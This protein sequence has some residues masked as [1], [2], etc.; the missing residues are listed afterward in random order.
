VVRTAFAS[1]CGAGKLTVACSGGSVDVKTGIAQAH[2][3]AKYALRAQPGARAKL[4]GINVLLGGQA[5]PA[6]VSRA[7]APTLRVLGLCPSSSFHRHLHITSNASRSQ[8]R[9]NRGD[10][11]LANLDEV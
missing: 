6:T 2:P 3:R 8:T 5:M 9:G 1:P 10:R 11:P 7:T 4:R